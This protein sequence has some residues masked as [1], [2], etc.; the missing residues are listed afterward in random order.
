MVLADGSAVECDWLVLALGSDS[1]F[2]GIEGVKEHCLPFNTYNDAMRVPASPLQ[3][4]S[5]RLISP[6]VS[7][8]Y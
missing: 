7:L 6:L 5:S 2:V 1:V 3:I 4:L 8:R